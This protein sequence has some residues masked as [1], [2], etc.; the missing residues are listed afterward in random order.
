MDVNPTI[1]KF[2]HPRTLLRDYGSWMVL[3]RPA[4]VTLGALVVAST[5]PA[6][7]FSALSDGAFA[8]FPGVV[9]DVEGALSQRF[10]YDKINWL[11]LMMVDR[12]VHFHV[13]PRYA[14]PRTFRG[15]SFKDAGWPGL[16][17]LSAAIQFEEQD[18]AALVDH[19]RSCF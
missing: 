15:R 8:T 2:G 11:L 9:R 10:R 16:P 1:A 7:A 6:T 18:L 3:A 14:E 13:I 5:E 19:L 17:D 4:Q 12:E